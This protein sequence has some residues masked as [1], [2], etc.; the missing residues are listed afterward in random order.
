LNALEASPPG[1]TVFVD[2]CQENGMIKVEVRDEGPGLDAEQREHLFEPFYTTK[3]NGT[4]L[5]LAVSRELIRSQGGDVCLMAS[6]TGARFVIE[7][8]GK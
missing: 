2:V 7:L 1:A 8:P 5:G 4:G 6:E 3:P